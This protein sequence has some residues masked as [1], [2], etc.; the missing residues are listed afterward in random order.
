VAEPH[1][2]AVGSVRPGR[3]GAAGSGVTLAPATIAAAWNLQGDPSTAAFV[4]AAR[5]M[6]GVALPRVPNTTARSDALAAL[7]LGPASWLLVA[8]GA[9]PL[10]GHAAKRDA[11]NAGGGA[12]FDVSASRVAWTVAGPRA[13][14]VL[15]KG[16]P[17][18]F[19]PRAFAAGTCAQSLYGHVGVLVDRRDDAP[20]F[21][22]LV[23]RSYARDA[24]HALCVA[25]AQYGCEVL[26]PAAFR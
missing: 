9:S 23:A 20:A 24:W 25:S 11:V 21:T 17:L 8:G 12:L 2:D 26:A 19:H 14:D 1:D 18:D 16:C 4:D 10:T 5:R 13:A 15:A 22:L 3:Y 7:W 6:F